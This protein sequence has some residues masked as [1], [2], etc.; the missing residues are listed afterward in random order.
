MSGEAYV[1]GAWRD[2]TSAKVCIDGIN[3]KTITR[4]LACVD[5]T[6]WVP[7]ANFVP[8]LSVSISP[9]DALGFVSSSKPARAVTNPVTATPT[10]GKA[11]FTYVWSLL[12]GATTITSPTNASTTFSQV[13]ASGGSASA[14]ARVTVT[15]AL[16]STATADVSISFE[17][18][19]R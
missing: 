3:W 13:V 2:L 9:P 1:G 10:G 11:P 18:G 16:G 12:S 14:T 7:I 6:N 5:G 17:N 15:D 19:V 8:P 4:G